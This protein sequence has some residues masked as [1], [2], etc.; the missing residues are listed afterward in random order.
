MTS[1]F[2]S[3]LLVRTGTCAH[4]RECALR[5]KSKRDGTGER[6]EGGG[7]V[8]NVAGE[9]MPV[10]C[11]W[12]SSG[13]RQLSEALSARVST[14]QTHRK[15]SNNSV[16]LSAWNRNSFTGAYVKELCDLSF[17]QVINV[18]A[19]KK[20]KKQEKGKE[21]QAGS[22]VQNWLTDTQ[23]CITASPLYYCKQK[24]PFFAHPHL[25]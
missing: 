7:G 19:L 4:K 14:R 17:Y 9:G 15:Q 6:R 11:L 5:F 21:T 2:Q 25:N 20:E 12:E 1:G 24:K 22:A 16:W 23:K 10:I 8:F 18:L 13:R 3:S